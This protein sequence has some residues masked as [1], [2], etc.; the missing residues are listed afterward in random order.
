MW[1]QRWMIIFWTVFC[2][3][4]IPFYFFNSTTMVRVDSTCF[5]DPSLYGVCIS[6][7]FET[8]YSWSVST[9]ALTL[10][11]CV[12]IPV[13]FVF[14]KS[15]AYK[16]VLMVFLCV[17]LA[18]YLVCF[19]MQFVWISRRNSLDYPDNPANS[20]RYCCPVEVYT[21]IRSCPNFGRPSPECDPPIR[22]DELGITPRFWLQFSY[23]IVVLCFWCVFIYFDWQFIKIVDQYLDAGGD[24]SHLV[25]KPKSENAGEM[26]VSKIEYNNGVT[27]KSEY[28]QQHQQQ[29]QSNVS[30]VT[31]P[32]LNNNNNNNNYVYSPSSSSQITN[33]FPQ[34]QPLLVP[35]VNNPGNAISGST[36]SGG[37]PRLLMNPQ[38]PQFLK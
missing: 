6:K 27:I 34:H 16:V 21:V 22:Y 10:F 8:L 24:S 33:R 32:L 15:R 3:I 28:G 5:S 7:A 31:V 35:V 38:A 37:A 26:L 14:F 29:P 4:A 2:A 9:W 17:T 30:S 23:N 36:N 13:M 20:D 25:V 1:V 12:F 18:W 11:P 19:I